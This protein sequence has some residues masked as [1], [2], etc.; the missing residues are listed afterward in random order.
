MEYNV[1]CD[2]S[3]HLEHDNFPNMVIG[4]I[5][6][7]INKK[8]EVNRRIVEIKE[9]NNISKNSEVKW[10][11]LSPANIKLY[12]DLI[13]YFFDDDDLH[14]RCIVADKTH[15]DHKKYRNTHEKWYY[16]MYWEMLKGILSPSDSY[17]IYIDIKDTNSHQK[18]KKL[19]EVLR[20]S[21]YD[22]SR[23]IVK[24]TQPIRSDEVQIM[25]LVDI[26]IGAIKAANQPLPPQSKAKQ[27]I[28]DLIRRRSKYNLTITTLISEKK[29]NI[30]KWQ[31]DFYE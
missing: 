20:N 6:L 31:G 2:E 14:F 19:E 15:L 23:E 10:T 28:I 24:K 13:N 8:K 1:Y 17:N 21:R 16:I 3:C 27:E 30:F 22:F 9:S 25:Q 18:S 4:G 11:K 5:Y 26:I 12:T 7:D 29:L